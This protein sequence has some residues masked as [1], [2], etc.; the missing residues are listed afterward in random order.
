VKFLGHYVSADSIQSDNKKIAQIQSWPTPK[1]AKAVKKFLGT[2]QWMKKFIWGLQKYVGTL[3]PLTSTKIDPKSFKWGT[4]EETAFENIKKIM[5]SLP[6]LKNINYD[7][8]DPLWLFTD[9]SGLGL[10]AALFQGKEW[11]SASPIAYESHL[12]TPAERNYPVHEQEL[13]AVIHALQ[14]WKMLL[15]GMK[16]NLMSDHHSLT[17]LLKKGNLSC[18]QAQWT[19]ILSDFDL[20]FEYIKGEENSVADALSRKDIAED[21][22]DIGPKDVAVV[23]ALAE[24]T[25]TLLTVLR[26]TI[27]AAYSPNPFC[28]SLRKVLPLRPDS[29]IVDELMFVEGRLVIPDVHSIQRNL[30][31]KAH[32]RLG[33]L[34]FLNRLQN[35]VASSSGHA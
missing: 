33:H 25:T 13:L 23:A 5:T 8:E 17:Y 10:G 34:G 26:D 31:D 11:K 1:S 30:I 4:A 28:F 20:N 24:F 27:V 35:Y 9:A 12:M 19:E 21:P 2:I 22:P 7:S 14:K 16:V 32:K 6:C 18:R 15:L 29:A 3:T